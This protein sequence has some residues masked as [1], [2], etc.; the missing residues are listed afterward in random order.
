[1]IWKEGGHEL[2]IIRVTGERERVTEGHNRYQMIDQCLK[3]VGL[4]GKHNLDHVSVALVSRRRPF[5]KPPF[6][7]FDCGLTNFLMKIGRKRCF[8]NVQV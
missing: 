3:L 1:M 2:G 8:E 4:V 6:R 5:L 7:P